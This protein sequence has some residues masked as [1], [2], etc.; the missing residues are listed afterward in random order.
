MQSTISTSRLPTSSNL[1]TQK[2][3][4]SLRRYLRL[5]TAPNSQPTKGSR[6]FY[7]LFTCN[8]IFSKMPNII[9]WE[10]ELEKIH[11]SPMAIRWAHISSSCAN[12]RE[13]FQK[14]LTR[15]YFTPLSLSHC[16]STLLEVLQLNGLSSTHLLVMPTPTTLLGQHYRLDNKNFEGPVPNETRVSASPPGD[17]WHSTQFEDGGV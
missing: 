1:L 7:N 4:L 15:W 12:H 13:P 6:L 11:T 5:L 3:K 10:L 8:D 16:I 14:L 9:K 17:L 2:K